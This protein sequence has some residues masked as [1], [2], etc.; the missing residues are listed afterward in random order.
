MAADQRNSTLFTYVDENGTTWNKRGPID[1]A[2]NAIDGSTAFTPGA[3]LWLDSKA[4]R[5]RKA[6]F[7]DGTTFRTVRFPVY[8]HAAFVAI[9]SATTL[10]RHVEGETAAVTYSMSQKI[11]EQQRASKASRNLADHA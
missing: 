3:P 5:C 4:H 10:A 7:Q 9:T 6:V 11:P 1:A 2:I 8:T